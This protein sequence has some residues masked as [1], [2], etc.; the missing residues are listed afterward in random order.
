MRCQMYE[1][2]SH[3]MQQHINTTPSF[4][5][6]ILRPAIQYPSGSYIPDKSKSV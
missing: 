3:A 5:Q 1:I 2:A 6:K 4:Q